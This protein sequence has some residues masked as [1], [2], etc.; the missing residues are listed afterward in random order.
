MVNR[1]F[2]RI[3]EKQNR[4]LLEDFSGL[5]PEQMFYLINFKDF[6]SLSPVLQFNKN[7]VEEKLLRTPLLDFESKLIEILGENKG[8]VKLTNN[9]NLKLKDVRNLFFSC[10]FLSES[11][12]YDFFKSGRWKINT[13]EAV[14]DLY[15][16]R[17]IITLN[18]EFFKEKKRTLIF[19]EKQL[20]KR[21]AYE[22]FLSYLNTAMSRVNWSY[23][24]WSE[25]NY[26][27]I[28]KRFLFSLYLLH[29]FG[30]I[31]RERDFYSDRF[32]QAFPLKAQWFYFDIPYYQEYL[33]EK[34]IDEL[35][36]QDTKKKE[37][38]LPD[39]E[40]SILWNTLVSRIKKQK[41]K[42]I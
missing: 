6:E 17:N 34:K 39:P 32:L 19:K 8:K 28:Q 4:T 14:A 36:K 26:N 20:V 3:I 12:Y 2:E 9:G 21:S 22:R 27:I 38:G 16:I 5:S 37:N 13:E 24:Y 18:K 7:I 33:N 40:P 31:Y 15:R 29:K 25:F 23:F 10:K 1:E 30:D 35:S 11:R 42:N 41:G